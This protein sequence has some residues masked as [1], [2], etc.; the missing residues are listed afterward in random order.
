VGGRIAEPA[1]PGQRR[2]WELAHSWVDRE[3]WPG[4]HGLSD[5]LDRVC[6]ATTRG[7][8]V[9]GSAV[10]VMS[11]DGHGAVA[12]S[13]STRVR[14][15]AGLEFDLGEGPSSEAFHR[16]RPVLAPDLTGEAAG[17]WPGFAMAAGGMGVGATFSFPL[18][19][20]AAPLGALSM[21]ADA[22]RVLDSDE[23]GLGV[24]FAEIAAEVLINEPAPQDDGSLSPD[25][26]SILD[27]RPVVFQAQGMVM[28]ALRVTLAEA[29]V[30]MQAHAFA[31][32]RGLDALALDIVEGRLDPGAVLT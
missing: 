10:T 32:D 12:G 31:A 23:I 26:T 11:N 21:Y 27:L 25:L 2:L 9:A 1:A 7:L 17:S 30:R 14:S 24:A 4:G 5:T 18:Q 19:V 29:L 28:I 22:P 20:G 6:G 8:H 3:P 16:G 15:L 13:S